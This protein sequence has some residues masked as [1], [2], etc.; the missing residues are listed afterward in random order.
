MRGALGEDCDLAWDAFRLE[1]TIVLGDRAI[2]LWRYR[3]GQAAENSVRG[4]NLMRVRG[5][6]IIEALG[7]VKGG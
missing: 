4:V 3:W 7:Y 6:L 2:I 1:D 5:G